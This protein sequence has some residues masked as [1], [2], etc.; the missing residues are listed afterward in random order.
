MSFRALLYSR[1]AWMFAAFG[2][3]SVS[4]PVDLVKEGLAHVKVG[5]WG[6]VLY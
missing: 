6:A 4:I 5:S 2:C 3:G 1:W